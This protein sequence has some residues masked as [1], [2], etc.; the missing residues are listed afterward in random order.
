MGK[1]VSM[2]DIAGRIGVSTALVSFVLNGKAREKRVGAEMTR[3]ILEVASELNYMP[4]QI[5]RSLRK[6]STMTIGLILADIANPFFGSL[7]RV[8]EDEANKHGYTVIVGSSDE[9]KTK[10]EILINTLANRKV[11][12]FIIVPAEGSEELIKG[13]MHKNIPLV[14]VDRYFPALAASYVALDNYQASYEAVRCLIGKGKMRIVILAYRS[15]LIHM[16]Q[17]IA[18][19]IAAMEEG[20]LHDNICIREIRYEHVHEDV[21]RVFQE[22]IISGKK[23]DAL[24]LATNSLSVS[25][26]YCIKEQGIKIPEELAIVGFDGNE[27][28][29]FFYAPL[30]Y[31]KQP[32]DEMGKES[33][34]ILVDHINGSKKTVQ[35]K[36]KPNLI[37]RE[38]CG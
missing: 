13:I 27:S 36:L 18:G 10:T 25:A 16:Q 14:L 17:R 22:L 29:D 37:I 2:K 6:G 7:A 15:S 38:S 26:L 3:K 12:G 4:N 35:V 21:Q 31:V 32:L 8:I 9:S 24:F 33:V 34:K 19:Y 23:A 1:N 28:F 20:R 30:T 11:D 5:A